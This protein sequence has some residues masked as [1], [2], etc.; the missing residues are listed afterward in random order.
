MAGFES[1]VRRHLVPGFA[2]PRKAGAS[3]CADDEPA[4]VVLQLGKGA[5]ARVLTYSYKIDVRRYMTK[6]QRELT[7]DE[8]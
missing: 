3:G 1:V 4:T 6:Q 2:P 5:R 8:N 7:G